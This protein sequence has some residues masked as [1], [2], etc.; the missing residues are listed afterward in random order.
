MEDSYFFLSVRRFLSLL[1]PLIHTPHASHFLPGSNNAIL[2]SNKKET[3]DFHYAV[4][5]DPGKM[6]Q[7]K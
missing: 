3:S 5:F 6:S 4:S 2:Y 7:Q 1:F